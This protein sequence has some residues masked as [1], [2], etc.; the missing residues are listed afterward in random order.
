MVKT[1]LSR[2]K[3]RD[4]TS[5][6]IHKER[7]RPVRAVVDRI[8]GEIAVLLLGEEETRVELPLSRLPEGSHEGSWLKI[9]FIGQDSPDQANDGSLENVSFELDLAGEQEQ[10]ERMAR[11][12]EKIKGK[13]KA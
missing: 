5:S 12:L 6:K 4:K 8:E 2:Q 1:I 9:S 10:R 3:D 7:M 13:N 11:L